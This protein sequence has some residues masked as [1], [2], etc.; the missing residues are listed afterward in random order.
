M[1]CCPLSNGGGTRLKLIE[2]AAY[3]KA[4]V[5]TS[6]GAEGLSFSDG[7]EILIRDDDIG[8]AEACVRLLNDDGLCARLGEAARTK[9]KSL[10]DR[11]VIRDRIASEFRT[12]LR[13]GKKRERL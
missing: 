12:M 5:S 4:I 9:A 13:S 6:V 11:P 7:A 2:A 10:Y 8:I 3:G 1:V